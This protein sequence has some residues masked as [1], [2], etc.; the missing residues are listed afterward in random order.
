MNF[1]STRTWQ[2]AYFDRQLGSPQWQEK[3][4]LDFGGNAGGLLTCPEGTI[5]P[6]N[7]WCL[8]VSRKAIREGRHRHPRGH[9][10]FY[11][12]YGFGFNPHG[13]VNL[14]LPDFGTTFDVIVAYSVFTHIGLSE[15]THLVK[16]LRDLLAPKGVF[17][18]TFF[19]PYAI[20]NPIEDPRTT[21]QFRA[22]H[23]MELEL[24]A[25]L[26]RPQPRLEWCVLVNGQDLYVNTDRIR[27]YSLDEQ[28][29]YAAFYSSRFLR[30]T[31]PDAVVLPPLEIERDQN[32]CLFFN[33]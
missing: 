26:E 14:E 5:E 11:N 23:C 33:D 20:A 19:D 17:A 30:R 7:Y 6:H 22:H 8:D 16:N 25:Q 18:F 13:L 31:F 27:E 9:W 3:R 2:F 29:S 21:L 32:C 24:L 1:V 10:I 15:M 28:R 12:R 4:V